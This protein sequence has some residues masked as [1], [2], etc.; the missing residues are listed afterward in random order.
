MV[1]LRC[2]RKLLR[3]LRVSPSVETLPPTTVLGDWYA[4]LLYMRPQQLVVCMNERSLLVGLVPARDGNS[5]GVRFRE[6]VANHL[7]RIGVSPRMVEAEAREM[8]D[9]GFG[10]TA[11]RKILG[12]LREATFEL[13]TELGWG[14]FSSLAEAEAYLSENIYST[15]GYRHPRD[16]ALEL[17]EAAGIF[18]GGSAAKLH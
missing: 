5:L 18:S 15:T 6:A 9:I 17:F 1:T 2:T 11:R 16:L 4:N 13:T 14:R 3:R 8:A 12:C 7:L 10:P